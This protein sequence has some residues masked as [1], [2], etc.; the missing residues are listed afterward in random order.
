MKAN[1]I[2][3]RIAIAGLVLGLVAGVTRA[4]AP[5]RPSDKDVKALM[6]QVDQGVRRFVDGMDPQMRSAILRGERGEID[7]KA[8]LNDFQQAIA[9]MRDRFD[10]PGY[11]AGT[12]V[13]AVLKQARDL[14]EGIA[15][16]PGM[17]GSDPRWHDAV[18]LF[19][20][21]AAAYHIDWQGDPASWTA[22]RV[23]DGE[24]KN[25]ATALRK[26]SETFGKDLGNAVKK[27]QAL[28][29]AARK[30]ATDKAAALT[31]AAK[32]FE[33]LVKKGADTTAAL[34]RVMAAAADVKAF[35]DGYT[36]GV[37]LAPRWA[38]V[39]AQLNTIARACG[40]SR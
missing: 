12:E 15:V 14:N 36:G 30:R 17:S 22:V 20:K 39:D 40:L 31:T 38:P 25:A 26:A 16:R 7:V 8:S 10:P 18:P 27:D 19:V 5:S 32:S 34:D 23:S 11:S 21:L 9:R 33:E 24:L 2:G 13:V 37:A 4:Q 35:V 6:G 1:R 29:T 3:L 28:D